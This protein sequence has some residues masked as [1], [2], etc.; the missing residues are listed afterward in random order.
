MPVQHIGLSIGQR[1]T[2]RR[3]RR[4][5][6]RRRPQRKR[7]NYMRLRRAIV[8]VESAFPELFEQPDD[9]RRYLQL[10]AANHELAHTAQRNG[11]L[12]ELLRQFL[13]DNYRKM[14]SLN[15]ILLDKFAELR[16]IHA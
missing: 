3:K 1:T 9:G 2:Q 4:P 11:I 10:L 14:K 7:R 16:N 8:I 5:L 6:G 12:T 15:L 13:Q